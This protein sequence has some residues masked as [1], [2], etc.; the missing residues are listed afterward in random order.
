MPMFNMFPKKMQTNLDITSSC[1]FQGEIWASCLLVPS[2]SPRLLK[3]FSC[4]IVLRLPKSVCVKLFEQNRNQLN[5]Y[6]Y[7]P[8]DC[9]S[10]QELEQTILLT[11]LYKPLSYQRLVQRTNI[12]RQLEGLIMGPSPNP[13]H[14]KRGNTCILKDKGYVP[15]RIPKLLTSI[16]RLLYG[17]HS[18]TWHFHGVNNMGIVLG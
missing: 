16:Y 4:C 8:G 15:S 18:I 17:R 10:R 1:Q 7:T 12:G 2:V 3:S 13:S 9:L 11:N 5:R 14:V 6:R